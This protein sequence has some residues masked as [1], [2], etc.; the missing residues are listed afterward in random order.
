MSTKKDDDEFE[1]R[2]DHETNSNLITKEVEITDCTSVERQDPQDQRYT[3]DQLRLFFSSSGRSET[4]VIDIAKFL[5]HDNTLSFSLVRSSI[6]PVGQKSN[7]DSKTICL[8]TYPKQF[9]TNLFVSHL[10]YR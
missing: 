1:F 2:L 10:A 4:T 3:T 9:T 8:I 7:R 6:L 5:T